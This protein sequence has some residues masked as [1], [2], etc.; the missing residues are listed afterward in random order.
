[1]TIWSGYPMYCAHFPGGDPRRWEPDEEGVTPEEHAA[2]EAACRTADEGGPAE[3]PSS[4]FYETGGEG[5]AVWSAMGHVR[6]FGP[7]TYWNEENLFDEEEERMVGITDRSW[8]EILTNPDALGSVLTGPAP[9]DAQRLCRAAPALA[10]A[11]LDALALLTLGPG[12]PAMTATEA[13]QQ[14][15]RTITAL[16]AALAAAGIEAWP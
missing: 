7:G 12:S 13:V 15:D 3:Q 11:S 14:R 16:R 5:E 9:E 10:L 2:W 4:A 8:L 1:M 6:M